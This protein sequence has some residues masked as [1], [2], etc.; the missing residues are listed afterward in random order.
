LTAIG[1][2]PGA[3]GGVSADRSIIID[4]FVH[5]QPTVS[6]QS[7]FPRRRQTGIPFDRAAQL[8]KFRFPKLRLAMDG[9]IAPQAFR[10]ISF[11]IG[12]VIALAPSCSGFYL[13]VRLF[14]CTRSPTGVTTANSS[15]S[16]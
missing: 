5:P 2:A 14:F 8:S 10:W 11:Y 15:C 7:H 16:E 13:S 9:I 1:G 4:G 12:L 6:A 3:D